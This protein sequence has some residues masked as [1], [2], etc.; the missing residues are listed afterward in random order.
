LARYLTGSINNGL[1]DP[2]T[3]RPRQARHVRHCAP[4]SKPSY[5]RR[6]RIDV[7]FLFGEID[8]LIEHLEFVR[9]VRHQA[10]EK[11][12]SAPDELRLR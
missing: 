8:H 1:H 12:S 5:N 6:R 4:D 11:A 7:I 9:L 10:S 3:L 2:S